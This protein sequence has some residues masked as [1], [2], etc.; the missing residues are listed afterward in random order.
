VQESSRDAGARP[1]LPAQVR[2]PCEPATARFGKRPSRDGII[3]TAKWCASVSILLFASSNLVD[4]M[5][6]FLKNQER[7]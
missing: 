3:V 4:A 1:Q 5:S 7:R 6:L 2:S